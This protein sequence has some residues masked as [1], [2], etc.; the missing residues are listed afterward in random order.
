MGGTAATPCNY[1]TGISASRA[2]LACVADADSRRAMTA[3]A[4]S[5][6][7]L[8]EEAAIQSRGTGLM[9]GNANI[10]VIQHVASIYRHHS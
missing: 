7:D 6:Y 5:L 8:E 9:E 2:S 4:F 10:T 1:F 3:L